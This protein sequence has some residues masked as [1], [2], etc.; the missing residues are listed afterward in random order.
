MSKI[1][2]RDNMRGDLAFEK[3]I[4][5]ELFWTNVFSHKVI[6]LAKR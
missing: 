1:N 4:I 6:F 5:I 3:V 2:M